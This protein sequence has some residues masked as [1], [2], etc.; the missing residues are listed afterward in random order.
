MDAD[1]DE[2]KS[3]A[4]P[5]G[6]STARSKS[7]LVNSAERIHKSHRVDTMTP[8]PSLPSFPP[9]ISEEGKG[10]EGGKEK[11]LAPDI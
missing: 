1:L 7:P 9:I 5:G 2:D 8:L 10:D 3:A 4:R 11:G 6:G